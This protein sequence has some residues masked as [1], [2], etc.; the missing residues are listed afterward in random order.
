MSRRG[1]LFG[2]L[3][4]GLPIGAAAV[5]PAITFAPE[6]VV[7]SGMTPGGQVEWFGVA[8]E[9]SEHSA[10]IVRR[11]RIASDDDQDGAVRLELGRPVPF[12]SI[13]VAVDLTTGAAAVATPEGYPLRRLELPGGNVGRGGGKPDWVEDDRGYVE[14]LAV[15]PGVGAWGAAV[16]DGGEADDDGVYDGRLVASLARLRG[17][18]PNP[19]AA[20]QRFG[21]R[22]VIVVIDPNRMEVAV[23]QLVE[24]PQ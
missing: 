13:W 1:A 2:G 16:G 11:D 5:A 7:A 17:I 19:P 21:P 18:G 8:R 24:V 4:L 22:D 3:L 9:I 12:Q 6:A 15:R 14:I 20:P 10:T 23:R